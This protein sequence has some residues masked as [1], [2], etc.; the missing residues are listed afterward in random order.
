[1]WVKG[2]ERGQQTPCVR[3]PNPSPAFSCREFCRA[4]GKPLGKEG[5][6]GGCTQPWCFVPVASPRS[7]SGMFHPFERGAC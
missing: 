7:A 5:V 1:M 6:R 3:V 2:P 4:G